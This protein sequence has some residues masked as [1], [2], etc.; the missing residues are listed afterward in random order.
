[1]GTYSRYAYTATPQPMAGP[2]PL[3]PWHAKEAPASVWNSTPAAGVGEG[4]SFT[5]EAEVPTTLVAPGL[6]LDMSDQYGHAGT[7]QT[8]QAMTPSFQMDGFAQRN[9]AQ[10]AACRAHADTRTVRTTGHTHDPV[11]RDFAG[12]S[13]YV[14]IADGHPGPTMPGR[15]IA[16]SQIGGQFSDGQGGEIGP[17]G[18][19]LGVSRR[20]ANRKYSSPAL[21]AMYSKNS[22][23]GVLP[24][25]IAVPVNQPPTP[26]PYGSGIA[27]QQRWLGPRFTTPRIFTM[28][29]SMSDIAAAQ[30]PAP[31]GIQ[32]TMTGGVW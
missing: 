27:S 5:A 17:T 14:D 8:R 29:Q 25:V 23:R 21:G 4:S 24:Q 15:A 13:Q 22:L 26:V 7:A 20:W 30:Q 16:H 2:P 9:A 32:D 11:E 28:P 19:R 31:A 3:S 18:F 6:Q 10:A 12:E 1:M